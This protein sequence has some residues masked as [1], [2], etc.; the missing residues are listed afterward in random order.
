MQSFTKEQVTAL[1]NIVKCMNHRVGIEKVDESKEVIVL[2]YKYNEGE[3]D[4]WI[5]HKFY[6]VNVCM[7]SVPCAIWEVVD[8]VFHKCVL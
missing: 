3:E 8:V 5:D 6:E 7:S 2:N 1:D 4:E